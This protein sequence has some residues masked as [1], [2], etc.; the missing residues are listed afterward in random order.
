MRSSGSYSKPTKGY[1]FYSA[2]HSS[3]STELP[4]SSDTTSSLLTKRKAHTD[5]EDNVFSSFGSTLDHIEEDDL[6]DWFVDS[7]EDEPISSLLARQEQDP[8]KH[9]LFQEESEVQPYASV[10]FFHALRCII[11]EGVIHEDF[12]KRLRHPESIQMLKLLKSRNDRRRETMRA[13]VRRQ[14]H[15]VTISISDW[16]VPY[17]ET[18]VKGRQD[19][20]LLFAGLGKG[21]TAQLNRLLKTAIA[22]AG[23]DDIHRIG[24]HS[25]RKSF[26][27][28]S[29]EVSKGDMR[30]TAQVVGHANI[31]TTSSYTGRETNNLK[32]L[33]QGVSTHF[34]SVLGPLTTENGHSKVRLSSRQNQ[35]VATS[36]T[37]EVQFGRGVNTGR[38]PFTDKEIKYMLLDAWTDLEPHVMHLLRAWIAVAVCSGL[39]S[40]ELGRIQ[41][42]DVRA[43]DGSIYCNVLVKWTKGGLMWHQQELLGREAPHLREQRAHDTAMRIMDQERIP[44]MHKLRQA[45]M[46]GSD[47][48]IREGWIQGD[49][50]RP[51]T[52]AKVLPVEA[53]SKRTAQDSP[54]AHHEDKTEHDD[55]NVSTLDKEF[56]QF[57]E[58]MNM[59]K[60][61]RD[62]MNLKAWKISNEGGATSGMSNIEKSNP[63][64]YSKTL[65]GLTST[66]NRERIDEFDEYDEEFGRKSK[67]PKTAKYVYSDKKSTPLAFVN[68]AFTTPQQQQRDIRTYATHQ[69]DE[70][71]EKP[72][73]DERFSR[74]PGTDDRVQSIHASVLDCAKADK[75]SF[76]NPFTNLENYAILDG[77]YH[78]QSQNDWAG[79]VRDY[80]EYFHP[81]RTNISIKDRVRTMALDM[82]TKE[83]MLMMRDHYSNLPDV[84]EG[85]NNI[86]DLRAKK[87]KESNE[88]FLFKKWTERN[89]RC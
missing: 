22:E 76:K 12:I 15:S 64:A 54:L 6:V 88:E 75:R 16:V 17:I 20:E 44:N 28:T 49:I 4:H 67:K 47:A 8:L 25:G 41:V 46:I 48:I 60:N 55:K 71:N 14:D 26:A 53:L 2:S 3:T 1:G 79:I 84:R 87:L 82:M 58:W 34:K 29:L 38:R 68:S 56:H 77:Y 10:D 59:S 30:A 11:N 35:V 78:M 7:D 86:I 65:S 61:D 50:N 85:I 72:L 27:M 18:I 66:Q 24:T 5:E 73:I 37:Q 39:R 62:E 23:S 9:V 81:L 74:L 36:A 31:T 52:G 63:D 42:Q 19:S 70:K 32:E 51:G 43:P 45:A 13:A 33:V 69:Q 57:K 89:N 21:N 83:Q 80:K 40:S